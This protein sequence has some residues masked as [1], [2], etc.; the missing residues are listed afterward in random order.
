MVYLAYSH[1]NVI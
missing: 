1:Q